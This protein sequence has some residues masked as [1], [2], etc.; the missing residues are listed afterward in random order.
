MKIRINGEYKTNCENLIKSECQNCF[1]K[2]HTAR[3]CTKRN[4][5]SNQQINIPI[6]KAK[7]IK[8]TNLWNALCIESDDENI[9]EV[10]SKIEEIEEKP[11]QYLNWADIDTDDDELPP[12]PSSWKK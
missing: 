11:Y 8:F 1:K 7:E 5:K 3:Y 10:V 2:G 6:E 4:I 12:I 9:S